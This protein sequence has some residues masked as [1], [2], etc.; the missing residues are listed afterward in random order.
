[1]SE[2]TNEIENNELVFREPLIDEK[3]GKMSFYNCID[4]NCF[5]RYPSNDKI[6]LLSNNPHYTSINY[7]C[8]TCRKLWNEYGKIIYE[9]IFKEPLI[10]EDTGKKIYYNCID[11]S[12]FIINPDSY[13]SSSLLKT[14]NEPITFIIKNIC[15][16]CK[17]EWDEYGNILINE[18]DTT[19]PEAN[20]EN[21]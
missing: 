7:N 9:P 10:D 15:D 18:T 21:I 8:N 1:M 17:K 5:N 12:C 13:I 6:Q 19:T 14:S 4:E 2:N 20:T 11:E 3:T 16:F